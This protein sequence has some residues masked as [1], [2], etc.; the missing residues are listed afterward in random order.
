MTEFAVVQPLELH[1]PGAHNQLDHGHRFAAAAAAVLQL[2]TRSVS[3]NDR[4]SAGHRVLVEAGE[5]NLG[6]LVGQ[7]GAKASEYQTLL[8]TRL[9]QRVQFRINK[10]GG[11]PIPPPREISIN[12]HALAQAKAK[13]VTAADIARAVVDYDV[14]Y[15]SGE[16]YPDQERR[17][18]NG[19]VVVVSLSRKQVV[20]IYADQ[21]VTALRPDQGNVQIAALKNQRP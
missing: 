12:P 11:W 21:V 5:A 13:G 4:G 15:P 19:L 17:I 6:R 2:P 3:V 20:T 14:A 10:A 8:S 16:K 9:G 1:L 18:R 7:R